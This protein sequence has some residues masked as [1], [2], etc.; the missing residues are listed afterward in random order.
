MD[1]IE[2]RKGERIQLKSPVNEKVV[3]R[4]CEDCTIERET[5]TYNEEGDQLQLDNC[6]NTKIIGCTFK[7]K[8]TKG[9]FIH[10]RGEKSKRNRIER[11]TFRDHTFR[12]EQE[13]NGGEAIIIGLD[14]WTGCKF[15]T[16]VQNCEFINCRGDPELVSIKSCE[17]ELKNN[18]IISNGENAQG[19]FTVRN[20]GFNI[21]QDNVFEGT[22]GIRIT[23]DGN[24]IIGNYHKNNDSKDFRPLAI[25]NGNIEDDENIR[26]GKPIDREGKKTTRYARA[27]NNL[28]EGNIYENCQGACVVWGK[29]GRPLEPRRNTFRKNILIAEDKDSIFLRLR[30]DETELDLDGEDRNR[31]ENNKM[32]GKKA[33]RGKIP[34]ETV[35]RL[36][37]KPPFT[38]AEAGPEARELAAAS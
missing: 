9:N 29:S 16:V 8:D 28:I 15:K 35:E 36:S 22:G 25:E 3:L 18:K 13:N 33:E 31:F 30:N 38:I 5:F 6:V 34:K 27:K 11:C 2:N 32:H 1:P 4:N 17:N 7:D 20:G 37:N 24:K 23:G 14:K 21:I 10:I 19:N 26:D 12:N